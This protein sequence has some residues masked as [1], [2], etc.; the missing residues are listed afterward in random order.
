MC[1]SVRF[2]GH[3]AHPD[4]TCGASLSKTAEN[5]SYAAR[6]WFTTTAPSGYT[7]PA[8]GGRRTAGRQ[9]SFAAFRR[10]SSPFD[11]NA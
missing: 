4:A 1:V 3:I 11:V 7:P 5:A 2:F 6:A 9:R 8:E 10:R